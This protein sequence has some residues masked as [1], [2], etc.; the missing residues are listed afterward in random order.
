MDETDI[1]KCYC[2]F[3]WLGD[4]PCPKCAL[5]K[6]KK[7]T[8]QSQITDQLNIWLD[9]GFD[10]QAIL[11]QVWT[12]RVGEAEVRARNA[13]FEA[14][15]AMSQVM[16]GHG[17]AEM[18]VRSA[19]WDTNNKY[20]FGIK[21]PKECFDDWEEHCI[22]IVKEDYWKKD[23][24]V[25]DR[26]IS[27]EIHLPSG[28]GEEMESTFSYPAIVEETEVSREFVIKRLTDAGFRHSQDLQDWMMRH[29]P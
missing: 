1:S 10:V 22:C 4:E 17:K 23:R 15:N 13:E 2:G 8:A 28:F 14:R 18:M 24:H 29:D 6:K 11:N 26:H 5:K 20:I 25:E 27:G 3:Q 16:T 9:E 12:I 7:M 19:E 21:T